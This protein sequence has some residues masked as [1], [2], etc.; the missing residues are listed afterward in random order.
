M[1]L[2]ALGLGL[3]SAIASA[4]LLATASFAPSPYRPEPGYDLL[5]QRKNSLAGWHGRRAFWHAEGE[6]VCGSLRQVQG[7]DHSA[8]RQRRFLRHFWLGWGDFEHRMEA[9]LSGNISP[10]DHV[11]FR[12]RWE[13]DGPSPGAAYETRL[14]DP[15]SATGALLEPNGRGLLIHPHS[16]AFATPSRPMEAGLFRAQEWNQITIRAV[17]NHLVHQVNGTVT[18]DYVDQNPKLRRERGAIALG[19]DFAG[20]SAATAS[21]RHVRIR[22]LD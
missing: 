21:F 12:Y 5:F 17:A 6:D 15:I 8:L 22:T 7:P 4:G 20:D 18:T 19:F 11:L 2:T 14:G 9:K 10:G 16:V 1:A 13:P 3:G